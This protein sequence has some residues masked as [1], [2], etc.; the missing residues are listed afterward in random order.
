MDESIMQ[1]DDFRSQKG[2]SNDTT[3]HDFNRFDA[4]SHFSLKDTLGFG[5][6]Q[7]IHRTNHGAML[8]SSKFFGGF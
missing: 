3:N 8:T 1:S 4:S 5:N 7:K 6:Q 2:F